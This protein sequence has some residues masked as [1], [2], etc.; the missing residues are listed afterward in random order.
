MNTQSQLTLETSILD[1]TYREYIPSPMLKKYIHKYYF[2]EGFSSLKNK[3]IKT[4]NKCNAE[5]VIHYGEEKINLYHK[6]TKK[7]VKK[8][9]TIIGGHKATNVR[10]YKATNDIFMFSVEFNYIGILKLLSV[11]PVEI[12]DSVIDIDILFG[13]SAKILIDKFSKAKGDLNKINIIENFFIDI[14]EKD[15]SNYCK[16]N[17]L[18]QCMDIMVSSNK[19]IKDICEDFNISR[20]YIER[21]FKKKI[22]YSSKEFYKISRI[23][24]VCLQLHKDYP[25]K[26]LSEIAEEN[27]Y[28]D[29]SH[30]NKEFK[31]L[32]GLSPYKYLNNNN[33]NKLLYLGRGYLIYDYNNYNIELTEKNN[34]KLAL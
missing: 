13:E 8:T 15:N 9:A 3:K 21:N 28:V 4:I 33:N 30:F 14:L 24:N 18:L 16:E 17:L 31:Q 32:T 29:L 5:M 27:N 6:D 10:E 1:G 23:N 7:F 2:T 11:Y 22:G 12:L 26:N 34:L 19:K 25:N 20:R